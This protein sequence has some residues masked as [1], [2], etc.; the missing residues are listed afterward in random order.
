MPGLILWP[1][2]LNL[3]GW[4][5]LH[6]MGTTFTILRYRSLSLYVTWFACGSV[7]DQYISASAMYS[8]PMDYDQAN[9]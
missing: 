6:T 1:S 5:G 4:E 3:N 7:N 2:Q 8:K 9:A